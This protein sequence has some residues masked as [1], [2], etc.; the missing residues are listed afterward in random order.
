MSESPQV[1]VVEYAI[2]FSFPGNSNPFETAEDALRHYGF[3]ENGKFWVASWRGHEFQVVH[4]RMGSFERG[5]AWIQQ[6]PY[7]GFPPASHFDIYYPVDP[8][9]KKVD[10]HGATRAYVNPGNDGWLFE[11]ADADHMR[12]REIEIR[13]GIVGAFQHKVDEATYAV[14]TATATRP[15][16]WPIGTPWETEQTR[17][18]K[19]ASLTAFR[20]KCVAKALA[21]ARERHIGWYHQNER[22]SHLHTLVRDSITN[23]LAAGSYPTISGMVN[24]VVEELDPHEYETRWDR[25]TPKVKAEIANV[26]AASRG[27]ISTVE[28]STKFTGIGTIVYTAISSDEAVATVALVGT[29]LRITPLLTGTS[30]VTVRA[31]GPDASLFVEQEFTV[32]VA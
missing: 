27:A 2:S 19:L 11:H 10:I 20:E 17:R 7:E 21:D 14:L 29:E 22:E 32:T 16:D 18:L 24:D 6:L 3:E 15:S 13:G 4:V 30:T 31:T 28:L 1:K 26:T 8:R 5:R 23:T 12:D 25:L 9:M